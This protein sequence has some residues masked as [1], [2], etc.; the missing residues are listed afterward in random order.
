MTDEILIVEDDPDLRALL[1]Y[2]F[3]SEGFEIE[4]HDG[5]AGA[6]TYV[7]DGGRP[8]CVLLDLRMPGVNGLEVLEER[9]DDEVFAAIPVI[10]LTGI[11]GDILERAFDRGADDHMLKPFSPD[12]LVTKVRQVLE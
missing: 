6:L 12:E 5:G 10:V 7:E 1:E 2:T 8:S 3:E 11:D 4:S 9:A